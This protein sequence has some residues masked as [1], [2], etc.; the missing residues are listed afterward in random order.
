LVSCFSHSRLTIFSQVNSDWAA[1][2]VGGIIGIDGPLP[3]GAG[4]AFHDF[5]GCVARMRRSLKCD[6]KS[7]ELQARRAVLP[8][9]EDFSDEE[10][11][12]DESDAW[13]FPATVPSGAC[14]GTVLTVPMP[15][16][17]EV[18]ASVPEGAYPGTVFGVPVPET[19][20][21][22]A[23]QL[24]VAKAAGVLPPVEPETNFSHLEQFE[25][26][27][28]P[29]P[30][31][32][33]MEAKGRQR[34]CVNSFLALREAA[35]LKGKL[36]PLEGWMLKRGDTMA[37]G[38][39]NSWKLRYF[40]LEGDELVYYEAAPGEALAEEKIDKTRA[41]GGTVAAAQ[42]KAADECRAMTEQEHAKAFVDDQP[43][44]VFTDKNLKGADACV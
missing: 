23:V 17:V 7:L 34:F 27:E 5:A 25:R 18:Y 32:A 24:A 21:N 11:E 20:I 31:A 19:A 37:V 36:P 9:D 35:A 30:G 26:Q 28:V 10:E 1:T 15:G 41:R 4:V 16:G 13:L 6:A 40:R 14:P 38:F 43:R 39:L 44:E 8:E 22:A 2:V 42:Q 29:G 3:P 12:F 33:Y